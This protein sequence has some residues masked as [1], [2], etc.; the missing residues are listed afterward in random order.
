MLGR[1]VL[2][3]CNGAGK[4]RSCTV[5]GTRFDLRPRRSSESIAPCVRSTSLRRPATSVQRAVAERIPEHSNLER[6][7]MAVMPPGIPRI[8]DYERT[9]SCEPFLGMERF[10]EAFL[11][12]N[13]SR[14]A[15]YRRRWVA[16][17]LHQWSRQWEYPYAFESL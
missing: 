6:F 17:P 12:G 14:L 2:R 7:S 1:H 11:R 10:S 5:P 15:S 9:R 16:D 3:S 13:G 8:A 4:D